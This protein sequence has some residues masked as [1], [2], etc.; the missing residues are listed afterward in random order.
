MPGGRKLRAVVAGAA[1]R[2]SESAVDAGPALQA[3]RC[4]Q[5]SQAIRDEIEGE[6]VLF[7]TAGVRVTLH[8]RGRVPGVRD[9]GGASASLGGFAVTDRR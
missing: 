8:R 3:V 7:E 4:W 5:A 6:S 9:A 1:R 2:L